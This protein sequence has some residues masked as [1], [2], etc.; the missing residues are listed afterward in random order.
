MKAAK[1]FHT[2]QRERNQ[3]SKEKVLGKGIKKIVSRKKLLMHHLKVIL[4]LLLKNI[5]SEIIHPDVVVSA[6]NDQV[7]SIS[8][9]IVEQIEI[10]PEVALS[11]VSKLIDPV[12]SRRQGEQRKQGFLEKKKGLHKIENGFIISKHPEISYQLMN[13]VMK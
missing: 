10:I 4:I 9:Q 1:R 13:R 6:M 2:Q 11:K 5:S 3:V 7:S 12:I 8:S